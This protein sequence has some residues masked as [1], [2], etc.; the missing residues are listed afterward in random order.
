MT[1]ARWARAVHQA[2]GNRGEEAVTGTAGRRAV[3]RRCP[4]PEE[5]GRA[6]ADRQPS[7]AATI[8]RAAWGVG[9]RPAD[10]SASLAAGT[11][12][13]GAHPPKLDLREDP[14]EAL[15]APH[16]VQ[17]AHQPLAA[18][19]A[20]HDPPQ[21]LAA[22]L[23]HSFWLL[24]VRRLY[25]FGV[26]KRVR[27]GATTQV[28]MAAPA[29][30]SGMQRAAAS[31]PMLLVG[32]RRATILR[33]FRTR[34]AAA[35]WAR[36]QNRH[37]VTCSG[38]ILHR[39]C[40]PAGRSPPVGAPPARAPRPRR[41]RARR[42]S[43]PLGPAVGGHVGLRGSGFLPVLQPIP[44]PRLR[45]R[46]RRPPPPR[47]PPAAAAPGGPA[48]RPAARRRPASRHRGSKRWDTAPGGRRP[49]GPQHRPRS[50][51]RGAAAD[52]SSAR[53]ADP[54]GAV[55]APRHGRRVARGLRGDAVG[56]VQEQARRS[57]AAP[58]RGGPAAAPSAAP[59]PRAGLAHPQGP[60]AAASGSP[61]GRAAARRAR[62]GEPLQEV[63]DGHGRAP[64]CASAAA[65]RSA[66]RS[67]SPS[68]LL[69]ASDRTL[70]CPRRRPARPPPPR[71]PRP[72]PSPPPPSW[73][74]RPW[75]GRPG[76]CAGPP[77]RPPRRRPCAAPRRRAAT[78]ASGT[79][80]RRLAAARPRSGGGGRPA[81]PPVG[82]GPPRP[83]R[84][85]PR[86][87]RPPARWARC[88]ARG[89][90]SRGPRWPPRCRRRPS[91][92]RPGWRG[93]GAAVRTLPT[94]VPSAS[95]TRSNSGCRS[96]SRYLISLRSA[97]ASPRM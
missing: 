94:R 95:A 93:A 52:R 70:L 86:G 45:V 2:A 87:C 44:A 56:G 59:R 63:W 69:R 84:P 71:Q 38:S 55:G 50:A 49:G 32:Q 3:R 15:L 88:A 7:A 97:A 90:P 48:P 47:S 18:L 27:R 34:R 72:P 66:T 37:P 1:V 14:R 43:P 74:G 96:S 35:G 67:A 30:P 21:P 12:G 53:P 9:P 11:R 24:G 31:P 85:R 79:G 17:D 28:P 46:A 25:F 91:G 57:S 76:P 22:L 73:R 19:Q 89:R 33:R 83:P 61:R 58:G 42:R 65:C 64:R 29:T 81:P 16:P 62:G 77:S 75:P 36:C 5:P 6:A 13:R 51:Q 39:G 40:T 92:R 54:Q 80:S 60:A 78:V 68:A 23:R 20:Q 82:R 4:R 8:P 41:P 26:R 10:G